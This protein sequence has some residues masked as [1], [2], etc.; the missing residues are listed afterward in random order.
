M[1]LAPGPLRAQNRNPRKTQV[2]DT[3]FKSLRIG[4]N[5]VYRGQPYTKT[6]RATAKHDEMGG[7]YGFK[8]E[9]MVQVSK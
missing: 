7:V 6:G 9:K 3:K 8:A 2:N 4:A 1:N 5:F